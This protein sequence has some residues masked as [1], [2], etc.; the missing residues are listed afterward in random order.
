MLKARLC[1]LLDVMSAYDRLALYKLEQIPFNR[2][3]TKAAIQGV[4]GS[5]H[6]SAADDFLGADTEVVPCSTFKEIIDRVESREVE[7]GVMAV[8]NTI[9]GSLLP[10]YRLIV[11]TRLKIVGEV[12]LRIGQNLMAI[13]GQSL[14]SIRTVHSHPIAL[15]QCREY[16]DDWPDMR[17]VESEDT[18]LSARHIAEQQTTGKAAIAS[19]KAAQLYGLEILAK[20]IETN[21]ANFTRFW[22]LSPTP[23]LDPARVN[24]ASLSFS[25]Q[26]ETGN[27]S[28]ILSVL[29]FYKIN[30]TKIQ[31]IPM[32]GK[33]WEYHFF[34]DVIFD[35]YER[36]QS[37]IR[38]VEPLA[39]SVQ[40]LGEYQEGE[41]HLTD[42]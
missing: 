25:L 37:A 30:L 39:E 17:L 34:V 38:S 4:Q 24:K 41:K 6:H 32:I 42:A 40:V 16:F 8:E 5:F 20:G 22:I 10:N 15:E 9:A 28:Q 23:I 35:D 2:R 36:Y 14:T 11:K 27:L 31:S 29:A 18:A 33:A 1:S 7:F 21:P 12:Y 13:P 3:M 26:H 19:D